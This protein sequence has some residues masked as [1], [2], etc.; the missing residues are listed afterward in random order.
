[1][2]KQIPLSKGQFATVDDE[3]FDYLSQ[4]KW[5]IN[6]Y[7]YAVRKEGP[8]LRQR[9]ILMHRVIMAAP[10]GLQVDH[11]DNNPLNNQLANL[12]LATNAEN[13]RNKPARPGG[14]SQYKGVS[15]EPRTRMWVAQ[16]AVNGRKTQ[17][18]RFFSEVN[19]AKAYDE[20]ARQYFGEFAVLNFS[21]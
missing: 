2:S 6:A 21:E 4:W 1:M 11:K 13:N 7:G 9:T 18:G 3:W 19:A 15:W 12:R 10:K 5:H 17:L 14:S 16:I 8:R 20:A